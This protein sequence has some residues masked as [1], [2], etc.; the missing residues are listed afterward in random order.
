MG[1]LLIPGP[2]FF[3]P[4]YYFLLSQNCFWQLEP[5]ESFNLIADRGNLNIMPAGKTINQVKHLRTLFP[6]EFIRAWLSL[7]PGIVRISC[8]MIIVD[9]IDFFV[10]SHI[11]FLLRLKIKM[12]VPDK[13]P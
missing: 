3:Q 5:Y 9:Q 6:V 4:L 7:D 1:L 10:K 11:D 13:Q 8:P 2:I 12:G